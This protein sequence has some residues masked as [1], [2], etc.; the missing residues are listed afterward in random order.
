M[1]LEFAAL[2]FWVDD[3]LCVR[4]Y[5]S[6]ATNIKLQWVLVAKIHIIRLIFFGDR[7]CLK[8]ISN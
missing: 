7:Q 2:E 6:N 8:Q 1:V 4:M 5:F 3:L